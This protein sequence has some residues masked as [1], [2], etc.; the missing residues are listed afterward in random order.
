MER[1]VL[2]LTSWYMPVQVISW[3]EA[4]VDLYLDKVE[5][6]ID[7]DDEVRSP[8]IIM[9]IPAVVRIRR[10]IKAIRPN[11]RFS[12]AN[13]MV[14]DNERCQYCGKE[15][16][17]SEL[18]LDHVIPRKHG[19]KTCWNNIV[20]A[21]KPCNTKKGCKS[22]DESG[23]FPLKVPVQPRD[24]PMISPVRSLEHTPKEWYEFVKPYIVSYV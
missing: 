7:Y 8:S 14:R 17:I 10:K 4:I 16:T 9:K 11:V 13:V 23:M 15:K 2:V 6:I 24:L 22:A 5:S 19:G 18:T 12:K 1:R 21:C 3:R 20:S